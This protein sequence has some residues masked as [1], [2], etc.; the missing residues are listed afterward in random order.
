MGRLKNARDDHITRWVL[1]AASRLLI[2]G[3]CG[4]APTKP[5]NEMVNIEM[6]QSP[7]GDSC[8]EDGDGV[9]LIGGPSDLG[10][11]YPEATRWTNSPTKLSKDGDI[12]ICVRATIGEPR[13]SDGIYCLGR[14]VAGL[15][16]FDENLDPNF[17][18]RIIE[19]NEN[20][21]RSEGTGT[22]FKTI[23][24]KH[25]VDIKIPI[26]PIHEQKQISSFL[27]WL[28][29]NSESRPDFQKAPMLP[30]KLSKQR[31]TVARI[32][33]LAAKIEEAQDLRRRAAEEAEALLASS[34]Y[35][36]FT[37]SNHVEKKSLKE[38]VTI[39]G[40]GTPSK[41]NPLFWEG[42]IPWVSPKDMK[43]REIFDSIDHISEDAT[44]NSPA[45]I[46]PP[47]AVLIVVR[48][49]ILAH[50]VPSAVL[51]VPAAINQDMKA[52]I[53][54]DGLTSEYL[55]SAL[56]ALNAKILD[57]IEKSS[58]DTRK[59]QTPTLLDF[60][61][62]IPSIDEQRR[63]VARLD[64]LQAHVDG[65]KRLQARTAEELEALLP[66]VLDRAFRGDL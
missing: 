66:A 28:E 9:L 18:F 57:L 44:S 12:I 49:M 51:R 3:A 11:K 22:T 32:E 30:S 8:N 13:W 4:E 16:P 42:P 53:P 17:L 35:I 20:W 64:V 43:C 54:L 23:S 7:A 46:L 19:G 38:L 61:L 14:G 59:L 5:L 50:T 21:L 47:G 56:W 34:A 55:C 26:I 48:G 2:E 41:A 40:G 27:D 15:R 29:H 24:K 62:P 33:E 58:H 45:K 1:P 36:I 52:L 39:R 65:L 6:G 37:S 25:I 10:L 63:I 31:R 60:K